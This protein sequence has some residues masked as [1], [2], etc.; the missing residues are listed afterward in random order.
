MD[1]HFSA[2]QSPA[3][4]LPEHQR[5]ID[6]IQAAIRSEIDSGQRSLF[7]PAPARPAPSE[8][9][10]DHRI[11]E[12]MEFIVR[13]LEQLGGILANDPIL[14]RRHALE[15][16][17]I[18]LMKQSLGHLAQV[19]AAADKALAAERVTLTELKGRLQRKALKPI[20]DG[21]PAP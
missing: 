18:D 15:L 14:L 5:Q 16:Q 8:D 3:K 1:K 17:S 11:A 2:G 6:A 10:L 12:E 20:G 19:V 7:K 9:P 21:E 13:Q 4:P